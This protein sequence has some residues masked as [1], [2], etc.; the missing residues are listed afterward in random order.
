MKRLSDLVCA[1]SSTGG[2]TFKQPTPTLQIESLPIMPLCF[3]TSSSVVFSLLLGCFWYI[4]LYT[5]QCD[6]FLH[7]VDRDYSFHSWTKQSVLQFELNKSS[8][9]LLAL[10]YI[11]GNKHSNGKS[12]FFNRKYIDSIRVHFPASYVSLAE[13]SLRTS[14]MDSGILSMFLP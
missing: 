10:N 12:T 2:G 14:T 1:E 4:K 7:A 5:Q 13:G 8:H 11:P 9:T 6:L 3:Y